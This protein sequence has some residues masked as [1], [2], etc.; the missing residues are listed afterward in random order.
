[1]ATCS[2]LVRNAT[3]VTMDPERRVIDPGYVAIDGDRIVGVG[4][5]DWCP[6]D[7]ADIV[8]DGTGKAVLPGFVNAH[9]HS[10]DLLLR[11]GLCDDRALYDWLTNVVDPGCRAYRPEDVRTAVELYALEALR[12]GITTVVDSVEAPLDDW[13]ETAETVIG[14]YTRAGLRTVYAV[15]F[16][17]AIAPE[18]LAQVAA[19]DQRP[20]AD[21]TDFGAL[22]DLDRALAGI[23]RIMDRHHGSADGRISVWPSPGV[24]IFCSDAAFAGAQALARRRGV[25]TTVHVCESPVDAHQGGRTGVGHLAAIGYLAPDVLAGHCVQIS[26]DDVAILARTGTR[27]ATNP[28]S[29]MFLGNGIAPVSDMLAAGISVG[30]G[31]DDANC[32]GTVNLLADLKLAALA[33]KAR[34]KDAGAITAE[35]VLEL[36]TI[37]GAEAI[38]MAHE[39]GSLEPGKKADL[40][41]LDLTASHLFPRHS[42]ASVLVYQALGTE[43][44][45]VVIDGRV[46]LRDRQVPW[47]DRDAERALAARAQEASVRAAALGRLPPRTDDLWRSRTVRPV[48][49][50]PHPTPPP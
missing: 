28:V 4:L 39:I 19:C 26:M 36:A 11:G 47:L 49:P 35:E 9:T 8:I 14:V 13:D 10:T 32:N 17:D 33:Q 30:I 45:T 50:S 29:N 38:G 43:V 25:M 34:T 16:Y 15:M 42:V 40:A 21:R 24:A 6:Y 44:E 18:H 23:E 20:P 31:T 1:M 41:V 7:E 5:D 46:V 37:G 12:S 22:M 3:V 27:V 48:R 2:L